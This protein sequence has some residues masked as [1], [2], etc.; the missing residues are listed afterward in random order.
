MKFTS[1]ELPKAERNE[2]IINAMNENTAIT[3]LLDTV[4][5]SPS[6]KSLNNTLLPLLVRIVFFL[7]VAFFLK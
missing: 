7:I 1:V 2:R 5:V 4:L 6:A 3:L